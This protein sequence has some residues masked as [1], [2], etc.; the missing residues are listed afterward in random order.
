MEDQE[1]FQNE[2]DHERRFL[3]D[4]YDTNS[5]IVNAEVDGLVVGTIRMTWGYEM[6]F[7]SQSRKDY[8]LHC[9]DDIVPEQDIVIASR[10]LVREQ[11]RGSMLSFQLQWQLFEF[12]AIHNVELIVGSCEPH[13]LNSYHKVGW[14]PYGKLQDHPTSGLLVPI[15]VVVGDLAYLKEINSPMFKP[16]SLRPQRSE[17]LP[18][19]LEVFKTTSVIIEKGIDTNVYLS[20]IDQLLDHIESE[21]KLNSILGDREE[22]MVLLAKSMILNCDPGGALIHEGHVSRTLYILLSGTLE[23]YVHGKMVAM[24]E[25]QGAIIGEVAFFSDG[26]RIADVLIGPQ[27]AKVLAL[28]DRVLH[29][30]IDSYGTVA[31][32]FLSVIIRGLCTKLKR[33]NLARMDG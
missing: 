18:A 32:K 26:S 14:R 28:N 9:F 33:S 4:R 5:R 11:W 6:A 10:L 27:G 2:A 31:A 12:A 1:L 29:E 8:E 3:S 23:V 17:S 24:I 13:L 25:E 22:S 19:I 15:G 20:D 16:L 7:S 30:L 21:D